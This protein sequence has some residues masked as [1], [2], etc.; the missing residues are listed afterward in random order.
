MAIKIGITGGIGSGKS[1][2][3]HLLSVMGVPVYISD[4]ASKQL[5]VFD[6]DI[7]RELTDLVGAEVYD[8]RTLNKELLARY[9]FGNPEH[10]HAVNAIIHPRVRDDFRDWAEQHA[11]EPLVA[12]ESA[13]LIEA[14][15][16]GEVD[17]VVMVYAPEEVRIRRAMQRDGATRELVE[18]R[19]RSQMSDEEKRKQADFVIV[20]ADDTPLMPQVLQLIAS[21]SGN[22]PYLCRPTK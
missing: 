13:I 6:P 5:T 14:G 21:L 2:V 1:V 15:F 17:K 7:R 20:N 22:I 11:S 4:I 18:R 19:V 3:S 8:G 16:A 9:M 10:L 12:M